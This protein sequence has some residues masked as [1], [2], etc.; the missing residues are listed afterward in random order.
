MII[1]WIFAPSSSFPQKLSL[2]GLQ[3]VAAFFEVSSDKGIALVVDLQLS[4]FLK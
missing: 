3:V 4:L 1:G 2:P